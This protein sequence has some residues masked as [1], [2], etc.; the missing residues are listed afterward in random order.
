MWRKTS[1]QLSLEI[2]PDFCRNDNSFFLREHR[3]TFFFF[4]S[5]H[6]SQSF[7]T[8]IFP[9]GVLLRIF[10]HHNHIFC[11]L[12]T[13][14]SYFSSPPHLPSS[15]FSFRS[16]FSIMGPIF[17]HFKTNHRI[18]HWLH[19][20][21]TVVRLRGWSAKLVWESRNFAKRKPWHMICLDWRQIA[22]RKTGTHIKCV[23]P[24]RL[25]LA[26]IQ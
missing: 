24:R 1:C 15:P 7:S 25:S 26:S 13:F 22:T 21:A 2:P 3:Y 8:M 23:S 9:V 16:I 18:T 6:T 4:R 14:S 17:R 5:P 20:P 11:F 12:L 10:H 19:S